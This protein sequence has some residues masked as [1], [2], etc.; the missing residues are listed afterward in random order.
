MKRLGAGMLGVA[1]VGTSLLV[2]TGS[3]GAI[4]NGTEAPTTPW[5]VSLQSGGEHFC[6]GSIL[7]A[8]TIVTAAH[9]LEG[10]TAE[11]MT[12]RAGV[13]EADDDSGQDR[14]V[15]SFTN[16]PRY[17][18]DELGD[19]AIVKLVTPLD[20]GG[21]VQAIAPATIAEISA[22]QNATVTGWGAVSED[23]EGSNTL[24]EATVPLVDDASCN[25]QLD[26][27]AVTEVCAGGTG[28]DSCYG[29]SGGPLVIET[30]NGPRLAGITSWGDECGGETPGVYA[31]VPAFADF[32]KA[33]QADELEQ[34]VFSE[35]DMAEFD[36]DDDDEGND[37]DVEELS[38]DELD[39]MTDEEFYAYVDSLSDEQFENLFGEDSEF[40]DSEFEDSA[41]ED[42]EFEDSE[43]EDSEFEDSAFEDSAF[44]DMEFEDI[45][46]DD[47]DADKNFDLDALDEL[48][49]DEYFD[50]VDSLTDDEYEALMAAYDIDVGTFEDGEAGDTDDI[51][52]DVEWADDLDEVD[53]DPAFDLEQCPVP[54]A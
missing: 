18:Q 8:N 7:D 36:D 1:I 16:H 35:A 45:D 19:I 43:F 31:E 30:P 3:A 24:L 6:G 48:S 23:G 14:P 26:T 2:G 42:S 52:P 21:A 15:A 39:A 53:F 32:L 33:G 4:V 51:D 11:G 13:S 17:A 50:F 54:A 37:F 10:E 12:I 25:A 27:D 47:S 28:T 9:C 49:D 20:L 46:I 38:D 29:D 44:E 41:F 34:T 5:Q 22:A 40:E